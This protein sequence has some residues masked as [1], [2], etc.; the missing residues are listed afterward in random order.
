MSRERIIQLSPYQPSW[1][2]RFHSEKERLQTVFGPA[3]LEIEHIASTAIEGLPAKPIIDI[4]V[5]VVS[6]E[7]ADGFTEGLAQIGYEHVPPSGSFERH[8]YTKG[9]PIQ[10][11]LSIAYTDLGGFW[12]RQILFRDYLRSS[13]EARDEY[14]KLKG[15]LIRAYPSG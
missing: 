14:A 4:A 3:A 5:M 11:H 10:Y 2:E 1:K 9:D 15:Q 13:Q 12:D 6:H 8:F 7:D